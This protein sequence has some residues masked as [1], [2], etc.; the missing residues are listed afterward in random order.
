MLILGSYCDLFWAQK[1]TRDK[2]CRKPTF[3]WGSVC[4]VSL[5]TYVPDDQERGNCSFPF[6]FTSLFWPCL[7]HSHT[8]HHLTSSGVWSCLTRDSLQPSFHLFRQRRR[9]GSPGSVQVLSA[10]NPVESLWVRTFSGSATPPQGSFAAVEMSDLG[11]I[12]L[13]EGRN[14]ATFGRRTC[15]RRGRIS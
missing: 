9:V 12:P 10:W 5:A 4:F 15:V 8:P 6:L 14:L 7:L 11:S 2:D 1:F 3:D 13:R